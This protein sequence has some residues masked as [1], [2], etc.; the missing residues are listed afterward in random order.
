MKKSRR[1]FIRQSTLSAGAV[2]AALTPQVTAAAA[3]G[4]S[5]ATA[6]L[7]KPQKLRALL[8]KPGLVLAP[9]AFTPLT[10]KLAE[11]HGFEAIYIGGNMMSEVYLAV[12]DWGVIT[13]TDLLTIASRIADHVSIPAIV[14]GDQGG[15]TNLNVY[16][17]VQEYE[18]AGIAG[19]HIE[20]ALNPK[21]GNQRGGKHILHSPERM[22]L[23]IRAA[24]EARSDP[25][26][27]LIAR[28]DE[29][30]FDT[31]I[32]KGTMYAKAGADVFMPG[33]RR[34]PEQIDRLAG[35]VGLPILTIGYPAPEY[36]GSK[37][38]VNIYPGFVSGP[39]LAVADEL[40]REL[41]ANQQVAPR[42][43]RQISKE[44]AAL[45]DRLKSADLYARLAG[46][47]EK[48]P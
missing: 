20:D 23:R 22:V 8:Q 5:A 6:K 12:P 1:T 24:V 26:F 4:S 35:E 21:H 30:D 19:M 37:L 31:L 7:S 14:D 27:V 2:A 11:A 10:A 42:P 18:A 32:R 13:N 25:N 48:T 33:S 28:C 38:K 40:Y 43:E 47:W 3:Q 29:T 39:S 45:R 41:K 46:E 15:E 9:E 44:L 17:V 16:R 34:T 36:R